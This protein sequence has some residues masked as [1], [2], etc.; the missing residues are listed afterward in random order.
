MLCIFQ[1]NEELSDNREGTEELDHIAI[2]IRREGSNSRNF[3]LIQLDK[4][5]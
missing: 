1:A 5:I 2:G 3:K 4:V